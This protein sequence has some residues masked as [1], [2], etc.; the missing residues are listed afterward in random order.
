MDV[1]LWEASP[2]AERAKIEA[3]KKV[4]EEKR[5]AG[6][7]AWQVYVVSERVG[8]LALWQKARARAVRV[9]ED[10][11][12]KALSAV[13]PK[14]LIYAWRYMDLVHASSEEEYLLAP[15]HHTGEI[16][17]AHRQAANQHPTSCEAEEEALCRRAGKRPRTRALVACRKR[18]CKHHGFS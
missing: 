16:A 10:A 8:Q 6:Q 2:L 17:L 5:A 4:E 12:A 11:R 13:R 15:D 14:R 18:S 3:E 1:A 9:A 7:A